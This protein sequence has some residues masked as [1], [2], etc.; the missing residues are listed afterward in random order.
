MTAAS[1]TAEHTTTSVSVER[2]IS[3]PAAAVFALL[4]DPAGHVLLDG[5]GTVRASR[6][7]NPQQLALGSRFG[8]DMRLGVPYRMRNT[9]LEFEPDRR[10]AWQQGWGHHIWRY[11]LTPTVHG[12]LVRETFDWAPARAKWVLRLM[13]A[14]SRNEVAM[15]ATLQR[16]HDHFAGQA[17][18]A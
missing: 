15:R 5:S 8:M 3:A 2:E 7:G 11:E 6:D 13:R 10:I 1:Q 4:A 18:H 16:M 12:T 14:A 17:P 9:V